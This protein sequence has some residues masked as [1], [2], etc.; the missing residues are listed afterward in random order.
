MTV[1]ADKVVRI[2]LVDDH[3]VLRD[4]LRVLLENEADLC[5]VGEAGT[6]AQALDLSQALAPDVII[7]DLGLPDVSGIDVIHSIRQF[8]N[9]VR[10]IV[11]SMYSRREFVVPAIEAGCDG[12]VPKSSTHTSLL[13]AIRTVLSGEQYLHPTAATAFISALNDKESESAQFAAL[14]ERE[15]DV[16]RLTAQG[17]TS[18]EIGE[19]LIISAKTVESYRLRATEK[20]NLEH[21]SDLIRFAFRAGLLDDFKSPME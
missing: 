12:Y 16:L 4:G 18:R 5:V 19:K 6:G 10:I 14:S 1:S 15:Q 3:K 21:R 20:L 7:L 2:L 8:D 17:F 11:L 9:R 13:Q